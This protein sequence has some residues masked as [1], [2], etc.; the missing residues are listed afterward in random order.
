MATYDS[1]TSLHQNRLSAIHGWTFRLLLAFCSEMPQGVILL[2]P[3]HALRASCPPLSHTLSSLVASGFSVDV[4]GTTQINSFSLGKDPRTRI[5]KS[6]GR[7]TLVLVIFAR[8]PS[9]TV[10]NT[11]NLTH[12]VGASPHPCRSWASPSVKPFPV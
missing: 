6:K 2:R 8:S 10:L 1:V 11:Y 3:A 12:V 5:L 7:D 9:G 4:W